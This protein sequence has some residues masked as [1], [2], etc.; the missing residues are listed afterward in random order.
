MDSWVSPDKKQASGLLIG[1]SPRILMGAV[2]HVPGAIQD[3]S[4]VGNLSRESAKEIL[5]PR[6]PPD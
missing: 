6:L 5:P 1:G 2:A 3:R 4:E